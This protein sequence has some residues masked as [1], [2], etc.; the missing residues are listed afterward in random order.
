MGSFAA[1]VYPHASLQCDKDVADISPRICVRIHSIFA[2]FQ[3]VQVR[4]GM[5]TVL[6]AILE[7]LRNSTARA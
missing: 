4:S 7:T 6:N 3:V 5:A 2:N 1:H